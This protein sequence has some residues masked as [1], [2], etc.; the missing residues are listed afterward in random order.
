MK[1]AAFAG[2]CAFCRTYTKEPGMTTQGSS[3]L[4]DCGITHK[5][6]C[7]VHMWQC[8]AYCEG[9]DGILEAVS[10]TH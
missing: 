4:H 1:S 7:R 9:V 10:F 5:E 6:R 2:A 3:A 8:E